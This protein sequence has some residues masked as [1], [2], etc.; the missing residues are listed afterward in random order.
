MVTAIKRFPLV[1]FFVLTFMLNWLGITALVAGYFPSFGEWPLVYDGHLI[2]EIRGRRTLL[3]WTPTFAA[4]IIA[5]TQGGY[6]AVSQLMRKF[7]IWRVKFSWWVCVF[8]LPVA[9]AVV[10]VLFF[11]VCQGAPDLGQSAHWAGVFSLR[12]LFS[13]TTGGFG[14]EAG[15]RGFALPL[16]QKRIGP[17]WASLVI[18]FIW[19][20]WHLAHWTLIGLSLTSVLILCVAITGLSVILTWV[21]N[22]T[23]SLLLVAL[24]HVMFN[25]VEATFSRSF[26]FVMSGEVFL[27]I[28]ACVMAVFA[29]LLAILTRG[30]LQFS[31][32]NDR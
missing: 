26:A 27:N 8:V 22:S 10:T 17:L 32:N 4:M 24:M 15:W 29:A 9:L 30:K 11:A 3:V 25:A 16:L 7:L 31:L 19:S 5:G 6:Q 1:S 23:Q 28:F 20:I 12:F 13:L 21:Y 18:G 2:A 14:E